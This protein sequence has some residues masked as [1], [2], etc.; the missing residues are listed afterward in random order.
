METCNLATGCSKQLPP[1]PGFQEEEGLFNKRKKKTSLSGEKT[2]S[3]G[4]R[5][6]MCESEVFRGK[7]EGLPP[8]LSF[9]A[10]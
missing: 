4:S 10:M 2:E 7:E 1:G 9:S 8:E 5:R 6:Q 3:S